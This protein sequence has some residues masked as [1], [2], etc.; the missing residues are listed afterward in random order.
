MENYNR[1]ADIEYRESGILNTVY[2][3][4]TYATTTIFMEKPL[5]TTYTKNLLHLM[6]YY[7]VVLPLP[8]PTL[9]Y[10]GP[11]RKLNNKF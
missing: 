1:N 2:K 8:L 4:T 3:N 11:Y 10:D 7:Y 5:Q 9:L 6:V